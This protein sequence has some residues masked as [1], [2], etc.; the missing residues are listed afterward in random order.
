MLWECYIWIILLSFWNHY[1]NSI[2]ERF[3]HL[4][5]DI[6]FYVLIYN[7]YLHILYYSKASQTQIFVFK[8]LFS[9][10]MQTLLCITPYKNVFSEY[11]LNLQ[12]NQVFFQCIKN[13]F[14][15]LCEHRENI[16]LSKFWKYHLNI[17]SMSK[18]HILYTSRTIFFL[19]YVN[20]REIFYSTL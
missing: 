18:T 10:V 4:Q 14:S 8:E 7:I 15:W 20:I 3:L 11:F 17:L 6:I 16:I 13:Y 9:L 1:E 2:S 19:V 12:N 5:N